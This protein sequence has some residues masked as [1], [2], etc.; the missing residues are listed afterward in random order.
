MN[1]LLSAHFQNTLFIMR[2]EYDS[3]RVSIFTIEFE[4]VVNRFL[5][6]YNQVVAASCRFSTD[7]FFHFKH[8]FIREYSG[9]FEKNRVVFEGLDE[10]YHLAQA[11]K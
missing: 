9:S 11:K 7:P 2:N 3:G 6:C 10:F 4:A 5:R 1:S 8:D